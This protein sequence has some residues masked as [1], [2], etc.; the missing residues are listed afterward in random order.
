[1]SK[2]SNIAFPTEAEDKKIQAGAA[3]DADTFEF[4]NSQFKT[5]RRGRPFSA[6]PKL[7]VTL[8]LDQEVVAHFKSSGKGWQSRINA[9][10][11][12]SAGV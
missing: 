1:M 9:A 6:N 11:R 3:L 10:L 7:S 12:K 2:K 8:R 4:S 5:A